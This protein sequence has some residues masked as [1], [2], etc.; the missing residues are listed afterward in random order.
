MGANLTTVDGHID[1]IKRSRE[2]YSSV[3]QRFEAPLPEMRHDLLGGDLHVVD[4]TVQ[5][6]ALR[7][8]VK[9]KHHIDPVRLAAAIGSTRF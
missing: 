9:A 2:V 6:V 8:G 3:G 5:V 1:A 4:L 7:V